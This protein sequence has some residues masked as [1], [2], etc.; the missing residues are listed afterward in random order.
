MR[1]L[2]MSDAS[3]DSRIPCFKD[4]R[5]R[6]RSPCAGRHTKL[7]YRR[8]AP[9]GMSSPSFPLLSLNP[10]FYSHDSSRGFAG[11]SLHMAHNIIMARNEIP[12][13]TFLPP[14]TRSIIKFSTPRN[15]FTENTLAASAFRQTTLQLRVPLKFLCK[16]YFAPKVYPMALPHPDACTRWIFLNG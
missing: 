2:R 5:V 4:S 11:N 14:L 3:P 8:G 15:P 10:C 13:A 9:L 6:H 7:S 12:S 16:E 1:C